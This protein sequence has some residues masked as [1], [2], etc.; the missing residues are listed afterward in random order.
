LG[1]I[2][3]R[4]GRSFTYDGRSESIPGEE[5][6]AALLGRSYRAGFEVPETA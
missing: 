5:E 2:A 3:L 4:V 6:A 1:N